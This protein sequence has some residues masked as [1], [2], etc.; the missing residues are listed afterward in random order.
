VPDAPGK[1]GAQNGGH[2]PRPRAG[3]RLGRTIA[4]AFACRFEAAQLDE[5]EIILAQRES[6]FFRRPAQEL[7]ELVVGQQMPVAADDRQRGPALLL[8]SDPRRPR[9]PHAPAQAHNPAGA[10]SDD[11]RHAAGGHQLPVAPHKRMQAVGEVRQRHRRGGAAAGQIRGAQGG[12]R[13]GGRRPGP[14]LEPPIPGQPQAAQGQGGR[15]EKGSA[16]ERPAYM[17]PV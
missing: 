16:A 5:Q 3:G 11:F 12:R 6:H 15:L 7:Q 1:L 13:R 2:L 14:A 10:G 17:L 8:R 9:Q 4:Q